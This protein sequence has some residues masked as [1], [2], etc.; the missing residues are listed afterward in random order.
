LTIL[1]IIL[2]AGSFVLSVIL[3]VVAKKL[4]VRAGFVAQPADDRYHRTVVPLGGGIAIFSTISI[5]IFA[6]IALVEFLAV[7]GHLDWLGQ[8]VTVHTDG[9]LSKIGQLLIILL[10]VLVLFALGL[11]DDKKHLSPFFK[12]TVQFAV[13][14]IAAFFADIRV[15]LFIESKVVTSLLSAVWIVLIINAFN[16]LDNMDGAS[17]GIAVIASSILFAA[18]A[19]SAALS[20]QDFQVFIGGLALVFIGTLLGFLVFNFPPAKIFMGDAGSLVVGFFVALLTLRTTYYYHR[21]Q[22]GQGYAVFLPLLVMAVP[23]YDFISVTLLRIRQGRS[24]F[25]GDT[26]HFSHRLKK[27]GLT[28]TQTVLTLY[29]ATLCTGLG[30]IFLY[31]VNLAGAILIF[32][33][34]V[35]VLSIVAIFETTAQND[36]AAD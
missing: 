19:I 11:W 6:A 5:I 4:A 29:L 17:A 31:Q 27:H 7:P 30:A 26:Q 1:A 15:E 9:F 28:D 13:A 2:L 18:S 14:I 32:I 21:A 10:V 22:S 25:I 33:Q 35:M 36:K 12:L 24:P 23:L 34:T 20:G 3:T 16:F 8:S